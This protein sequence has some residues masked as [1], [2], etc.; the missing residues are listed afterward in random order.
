MPYGQTENVAMGSVSAAGALQTSQGSGITVTPEAGKT[1]VYRLSIAGKTPEDGMLLLTA[2]SGGTANGN[3]FLVYE[4][5]GSDFLIHA[6]QCSAD[7]FAPEAFAIDSGF[8]FSLVDFSAAA[9]VDVVGRQSLRKDAGRRGQLADHGA[10]WRQ[11]DSH[12]HPLGTSD[13]KFD[14][15]ADEGNR[16]DLQ[17]KYGNGTLSGLQGVALHAGLRE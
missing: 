5:D 13:D 6:Y 12:H 8:N 3:A 9:H 16:A 17:V 4:Q 1:G 14:L 15:W 10:E 7:P 11:H 2:T